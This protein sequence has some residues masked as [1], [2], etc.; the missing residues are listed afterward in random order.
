LFYIFSKSS[1]GAQE[2]QISLANSFDLSFNMNFGCNDIGADGMVFV[3]NTSSTT[4]GTAGGDIG[5]G[6]NF[7]TSL[8]VEF[9]T[10]N[11]GVNADLIAD[12]IA[13]LRDGDVNHNNSNSLTNPVNASPT[14]DNIEDCEF[15]P[16]RI[17]WNAE[18]MLLEVFHILRLMVFSIPLE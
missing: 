18:N 15:H 17:N 14:S 16:V 3:L 6:I 12:H 9:D 10:Y 7:N 13:I 1:T 11:N 2:N 5:Y 8:G 4:L